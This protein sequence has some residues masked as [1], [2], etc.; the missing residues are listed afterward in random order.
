MGFV[1]GILYIVT[2]YLSPDTI[3]GPLAAYRVE[4]ILAALV[5]LVSLPS[6][7]GSFFLGKTSQSLALVGLAIAVLMS[8]LVGEHWAGGGVGA[9]LLFIPNAF[10]YFLILPS[11]ATRRRE[12]QFIVAVM[13]LRLRFA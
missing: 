2:Y 5:V 4:F 1:L 6:L 3:F 11:I 12:L 7:P 10:A 13:L 9:F 8:V